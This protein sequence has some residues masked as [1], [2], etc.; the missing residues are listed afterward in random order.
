MEEEL[1][2]VD[3]CTTNFILRETK[4]FQTLTRRSKNVLTI[5]GRDVMIV[6]F[7]RATI[8]FPNNT[9]VTIEEV[10]L[11]PDSTH[12]LISF[13]DIRKSELHVYTYEEN[14]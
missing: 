6:G 9:Q 3:S 11:Y 1:C 13:R 4:Y 12:T 8:T 10:L 14:K 7:E 5:I 2:L